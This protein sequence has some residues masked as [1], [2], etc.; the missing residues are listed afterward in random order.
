MAALVNAQASQEREAAARSEVITLCGVLFRR[1]LL[2]KA[3][4]LQVCI[5]VVPPSADDMATFSLVRPSAPTPNAVTRTNNLPAAQPADAVGNAS[6][7]SEDVRDVGRQKEEK[8]CKRQRQRFRAVDSNREHVTVVVLCA[9]ALVKRFLKIGDLIEFTGVWEHDPKKDS[10]RQL[11]VKRFEDIQVVQMRHYSGPQCQGLRAEFEPDQNTKKNSKAE[12]KETERIHKVAT[13]RASETTQNDA[14]AH[15]EL[16][17]HR[18]TG[19]RKRKQ[20]EKLADLLLHIFA[21]NNELSS[22]DGVE[23]MLIARRV[24]SS[25][26]GVVDA[27]GGS[28]FV[29]LALSFRGVKSTV[30]DPRESV[31]CLPRRDRRALRKAAKRRPGEVVEFDKLRAWFGEKT[32]GADL[33]FDGGQDDAKIPVCSSG[34]ADGLLAACSAVVALHPDEATGAVVEWAVR[35][36]KPFVVVPCCVFSRLFPERKTP[37]GHPVRSYDELIAWIKAKDPAIQTTTLD[38]PGKNVAVWATWR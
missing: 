12:D 18:R 35:A 29:S 6:Y 1:T 16:R 15:S 24:L 38:F 25:G 13:V 21:E 4:F 7:S 28:G 8:E 37:A 5:C 3:S 31:G 30:V 34:S 20:A 17:S 14:S 23:N 33:E 32:M 2:S 27:A 36:R 9:S 19:E 11:R 26:T 10:H 22:A